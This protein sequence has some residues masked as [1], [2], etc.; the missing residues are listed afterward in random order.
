MTDSE[1]TAITKRFDDAMMAFCERMKEI[2]RRDPRFIAM[3]RKYGLIQDAQTVIESGSQAIVAL[4]RA[5]EE[6]G[7]P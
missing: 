2:D 1:L 6:R 7:A 3:M 5:I 4:G